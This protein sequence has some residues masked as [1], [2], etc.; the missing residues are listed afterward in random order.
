MIDS[1]LLLFIGS[2]ERPCPLEHYVYIHLKETF[3]L[4]VLIYSP[5]SE[6]CRAAGVSFPLLCHSH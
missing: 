6:S 3:L 2:A 1:F 5:W 4:K